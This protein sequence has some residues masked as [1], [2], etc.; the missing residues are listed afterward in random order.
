MKFIVD[1]EWT[2]D[3]RRSVA[4][5]STNNLLVVKKEEEA[6]ELEGLV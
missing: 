3:P 4:R 5:E 2:L 6:N 1:G